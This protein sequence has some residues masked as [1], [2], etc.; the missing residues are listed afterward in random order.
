LFG[1]GHSSECTASSA[2][3]RS[4]SNEGRCSEADGK[5]ARSGVEK[6]ADKDLPVGGNED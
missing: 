5:T 3:G 2:I 1:I 6:A 4:A